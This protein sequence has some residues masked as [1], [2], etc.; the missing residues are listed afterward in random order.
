MRTMI[1]TIVGA[2]A[3]T[4]T[5]AAQ[6]AHAA[7]I[8][9]LNAA[10]DGTILRVTGTADYTGDPSL[11]NAAQAQV[12]TDL[13]QDGVFLA[14]ATPPY[15]DL[16]AGYIAEK[17]SAIELTWQVV[18]LPDPPLFVPLV[19]QLYWDM[20]IGGIPFQATATLDARGRPTGSLASNCTQAGNL[21]QCEN[22]PSAQVTVT[23][24]PIANTV[25]ASLRRSDLV[26]PATNRR[27]AV[28]GAKLQEAVL[29]QGIAAYT[30]FGLISGLTGD[31]A[32]MTRPYIFGRHVEATLVPDG[33]SDE[34]AE[35]Q[36]PDVSGAALSSFAVDLPTAGLPT[37]AVYE[38]VVR[39][40]VG[41]H[42]GP[43]SRSAPFAI[44]APA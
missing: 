37:D 21:I 15:Q 12:F 9:T 32:D 31:Q 23:V 17:P 41:G 18:D 39:S 30:G 24:D 2:L 35:F 42:C 26:D 8:S 25:T 43:I 14:E 36:F 22:I 10:L 16:V 38:A 20:T 29:F 3:L 5:M 19:L 44:P 11:G 33:T 28:D 40:C 13:P 27:L 4:L 7:T 6:P 1:R 34:D